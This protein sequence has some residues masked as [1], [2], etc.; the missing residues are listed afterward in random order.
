MDWPIRLQ[1]GAGG[2]RVV[3]MKWCSMSLKFQ[4]GAVAQTST[5]IPSHLG[6]HLGSHKH[7]GAM[8]ANS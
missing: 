2:S 5:S 1:E 4:G 8:M 6:G 7:S 3:I